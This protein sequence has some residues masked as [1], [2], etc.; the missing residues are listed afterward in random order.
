MRTS[1]TYCEHADV[2]YQ[3]YEQWEDILLLLDE[4]QKDW[5]INMQRAEI[6][7]IKEH[8]MKIEKDILYT[9]ERKKFL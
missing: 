8:R 2:Q 7:C 1:G 9:F 3:V 4:P 5:L 6:E